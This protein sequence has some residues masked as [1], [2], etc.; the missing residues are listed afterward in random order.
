MQT[1]TAHAFKIL[2]D[3]S[4]GLQT[5]TD[6]QGILDLVVT[7]ALELTGYRRG[8]IRLRKPKGL[9][10]TLKRILS[11]R[12]EQ[13]MTGEWNKE[14]QTSAN[15]LN[16]RRL[17]VPLKIGAKQ[18]GLLYLETWR[19]GI[20]D[21]NDEQVVSLLAAEAAIS[22]RD[23]VIGQI[24]RLATSSFEWAEFQKLLLDVALFFTDAEHGTLRLRDKQSNELILKAH[25]GGLVV[26]PRLNI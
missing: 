15:G 22:L 26:A 25:R 11:Y 21:S 18:L 7:K 6:L 10:P 8:W 3:V 4:H 23:A 12:A 19:A 17:R 9:H 20:S 16:P 14:L 2:N 13:E 1:R 5:Q 24:D